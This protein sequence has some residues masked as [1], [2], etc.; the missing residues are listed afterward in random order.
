MESIGKIVIRSRRDPPDTVARIVGDQQGA[1]AIHR[2][3]DGPSPCFVA[4][5]QEAVHHV[6]WRPRRS[7]VGERH[8][9]DL[10]A[11]QDAAIPTSVLADKG[12]SAVVRRQVCPGVKDQPQWRNVGAQCVVGRDRLGDKIWALRFNTGSIC[13]P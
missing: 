5:D 4:V 3:A 8:V 10:V 6:L 9:N 2:E 12:A 13:W 1:L 7:A 11:I